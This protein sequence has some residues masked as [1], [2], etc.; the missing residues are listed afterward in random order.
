MSQIVILALAAVAAAAP[1][2][3]LDAL[4][5]ALQLQLNELSVAHPE[6]AL[7]LGWSSE[8]GNFGV[9]AGVVDDKT[10]ESSERLARPTSVYDRFL[11]GSGTKPLTSVAVLR[12]MEQGVLSLDDPI[13]KHVDPILTAKNGTSM[14]DLFGSQAADVTVG[15]LLRMQSGLADFDTPTLDDDILTHGDEEWPP[16]AILR[17]AAGSTPPINFPPGSQTEYSSTNYV[18][19]GLVLLAHDADAGSDWTKLDL[20]K[21]AFPPELAAAYKNVSFVNDGPISATATVAGFSGM[22]KGTMTSIWAQRGGVL[23]WTC[24]N[25]AASTIDVARFYRDLLVTKRILQP[26]TVA[27]MEQFN[28][29]SFGWSKGHLWYGAGLMV[30][31]SVYKNVTLPPDFRQWGSY[32]G[33][34]GDTYGFLS[35]QGI[36]GGLGNA[37]FSVVSN[38]D[39]VGSFVQGAMACRTIVTA[40]KVLL[41]KDLKAEYN[42]TCLT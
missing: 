4:R 14:T 8:E 21:L 25:M 32:M 20:F 34:G 10:V 3:K 31:Q 40:A 33:H 9:A 15:D 23:G 28:V 35:E 11:F 13:S 16:Y 18:L 1:P 38:Q 6:W 30:E 5:D 2:T 27:L 26:E 19:A 42:M 24:G 41:G 17:A 22:I 29:L 12:L 37:S 39:Y 36:V 7:Q